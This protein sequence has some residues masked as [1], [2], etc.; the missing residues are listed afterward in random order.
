MT[1]F[2]TISSFFLRPIRGGH[3]I[4]GKHGSVNRTVAQNK[5]RSLVFG[6]LFI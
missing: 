1:Q 5:N 4:R 6:L 2:S 3:P